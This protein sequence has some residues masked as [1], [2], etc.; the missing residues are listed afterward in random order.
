[1]ARKTTA[2][3][4]MPAPPAPA[5]NFWS[6]AMT[7]EVGWRIGRFSSSLLLCQLRLHPPPGAP[8]TFRSPFHCWVWSGPS[9]NIQ[10]H[11]LVFINIIA[12]YFLYEHQISIIFPIIS[13]HHY[14]RVHRGQNY[15]YSKMCNIKKKNIISLL[16]DETVFE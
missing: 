1:M 12:T 14:N 2:R 15:Q 9:G 3:K 6:T 8:S 10:F 13:C 16:M 5:T 7:A 4:T 11:S